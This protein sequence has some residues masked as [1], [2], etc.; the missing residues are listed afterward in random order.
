MVVLKS[1]TN[2]SAG[3]IT[4]GFSCSVLK[5]KHKGGTA[6][7]KLNDQQISIDTDKEYDTFEV[8]FDD[9]V[10]VSGTIDYVAIG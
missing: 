7:I 10:V 2:V 8:D 9:F 1:G 6:V 5:V 3:T 4:V